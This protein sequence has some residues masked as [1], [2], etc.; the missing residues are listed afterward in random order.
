MYLTQSEDLCCL[1]ILCIW[2]FKNHRLLRGM[3]K[4]PL[5][6]YVTLGKITCPLKTFLHPKMRI[7]SSASKVLLYGS[8]KLVAYS[9]KQSAWHTV[10]TQQMSW[11][12]DSY[13]ISTGKDLLL[14]STEKT[15]ILSSCQDLTFYLYF[16]LLF[17]VN[18]LSLFRSYW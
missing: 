15:S 3:H 4:P 8:N 5:T 16:G 13:C 18:F 1:G 7:L 12:S 17:L 9:R 11:L 2:S 14:S 6:L 10:T